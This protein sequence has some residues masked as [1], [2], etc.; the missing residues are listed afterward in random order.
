M[1]PDLQEKARKE[2]GEDPDRRKEDIEAIRKWLKKQPHINAR[3][4]DWNILRFLRGCKFSLERTKEKMD[5]FYTCKT[6]VPEWFVNRDPDIPKMRE[7]LEMG[8]FLPLEKTDPQGRQVIIVRAGIHNTSTTS[9]EELFKATH[10]TSDVLFEENEEMSICGVVQILDM[11]GVTAAHGFQMT[12][13]VVKKA[14]TVWQDGY[15]MRPKAMHYINTPQGFD[16]VFNIF[17]SFMKEKMKERV[18]VHGA[19]LSSLHAQVPKSVLPAEYGGENGSVAELTQHW[20]RKVVEK[21]EW[22]KEDE[23]YKVDESKRPGKPK[24]SSDLFGLEGSFRQLN[25]D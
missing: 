7:L 10:L 4:D 3:L 17:K 19:N 18:H 25:V 11:A 23:Q 22:L 24:T 6:A 15:P 8:C 16:T 20:L 12:P 9:V 1:S 13:A 14:M 21:K 5:M 2:L